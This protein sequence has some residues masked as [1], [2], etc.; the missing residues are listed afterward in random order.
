MKSQQ[1]ALSKYRRRLKQKG[2]AR[3]EVRVPKV[4][5]PLIREIAKALTDPARAK[6]AR[7][8]LG[9]Q[10]SGKKPTSLKALLA[11]APLEGID[12]ERNR[13][14]GRDVDL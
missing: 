12:I 8:L 4:D 5:V 13:D 2:I 6:N 11:A 7:A 9:R 10:L 14:T 3:L 1:K